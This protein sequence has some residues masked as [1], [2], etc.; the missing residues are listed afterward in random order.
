[1]GKIWR[2]EQ[3]C[4]NFGGTQKQS[5]IQQNLPK[6]GQNQTHGS[7]FNPSKQFFQVGIYLSE[8]MRPCFQESVKIWVSSDFFHALAVTDFT[9]LESGLTSQLISQR[10]ALGKHSK[11]KK[12]QIMEKVHN[13]LDPPLPQEVLDFFEFGK[14]LKFDDPPPPVP[15]LGKI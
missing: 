12:S 3:N 1:M 2:S 8:K 14:N 11:K 5:K 7:L 4:Q 6:N 10:T 9:T 15:N 13:F